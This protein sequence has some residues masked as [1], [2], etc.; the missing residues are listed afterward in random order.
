MKSITLTVLSLLASLAHAEAPD[1]QALQEEAASLIPPFQQQL[2]QTVKTAIAEG[3]PA[4]AVEAC[5]LLAPKIAAQ[6]S[7][8]PWQVGRTALKVRNPE[9]AAD[10]WERQVL[11]RFAERAAAGEPLEQLR[12]G[13]VV[14]NEFRYLQAIGTAQPCLGCHG[15]RIDPALLSLIDQR[16]P[17]DQARGFSEG[18][19]RGAFSLRR[20]LEQ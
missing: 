12:H 14:G 13:E 8:A 15:E 7:E 5:N 4:Q 3:G 9:N 18:D 2:L 11:E 20:A 16:Y 1:T 17:D 6:H 10:A 19:L